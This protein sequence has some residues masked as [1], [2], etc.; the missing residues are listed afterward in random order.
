[1]KIHRVETELFRADGK[2]RDLTKI[3]GAFYNSAKAP[4][5]I[6]WKSGVQ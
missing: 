3:I 2:D 1:M 4:K 6:D 5:M